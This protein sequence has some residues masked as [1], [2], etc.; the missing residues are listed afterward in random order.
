MLLVH[1]CGYHGSVSIFPFWL[2]IFIYFSCEPLFTSC[3]GY[4]LTASLSLSFHAVINSYKSFT[5][6]NVVYFILVFFQ[7]DILQ[8]ENLQRNLIICD[9]VA[10]FITLCIDSFEKSIFIKKYNIIVRF[11]FQ[12]CLMHYTWY[13]WPHSHHPE[14]NSERLWSLENPNIGQS[15]IW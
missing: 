3:L 14:G 12:H 11:W 7:G 13:C 15:H 9:E 5:T 8:S 1:I 10:L 4:F 2:H 6:S